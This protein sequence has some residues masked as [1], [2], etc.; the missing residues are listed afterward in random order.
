MTDTDSIKFQSCHI[1]F[2]ISYFVLL[3]SVLN[4]L[5]CT[6]LHRSTI[7]VASS[8]IEISFY[9]ETLN[10][11]YN[12]QLF[13]LLN[14][15]LFLFCENQIFFQLIYHMKYKTESSRIIHSREILSIK[16]TKIFHQ[17]YFESVFHLLNIMI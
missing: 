6:E 11:S 1:F 16:S 9:Q 7:S 4:R 5:N 10:Q 2:I 17:Y 3:S 15:L 14:K 8:L 12:V 13:P